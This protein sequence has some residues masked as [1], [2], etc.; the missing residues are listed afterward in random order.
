MA[1]NL[2][3]YILI[4]VPPGF[5][6]TSISA[7]EL[8]DVTYVVTM[9]NGGYE[10]QHTKRALE[11][12]KDW[13]DY[14]KRVKP[15]FTRV[16][17]CDIASQRRLEQALGEPV[18]AVIPNAYQIVSE[19]ANNGSMAVDIEPDSELSQSV[20]RLAEKVIGHH[21]IRWDKP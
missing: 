8:S 16:T 12:F 15:V 20:N 10:L 14:D 2:F 18:E 3:R 13:Q 6:P 21:H 17:P 5:T 11:I 19:A 9:L 4:D 7:A 1:R